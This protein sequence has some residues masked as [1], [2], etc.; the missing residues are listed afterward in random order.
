MLKLKR[1]LE[2]RGHVYFQTIRPEV[3]LNALNWLKVNDPSYNNISEDIGNI[4]RDLTTSQQNHNV[5]NED[6]SLL[7]GD[8]IN[9][10]SNEQSINDNNENLANGTMTDRVSPTTCTISETESS[11]D[12][13]TPDN[14]EQD[15][16]LNNFRSPPNETC[17]LQF[18]IPDN[19]SCNRSRE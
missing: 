7:D 8:M 18:I 19:L 4:G 2:F 10:S 15:D 17:C 5:S 3:V 9:T 16:P 14:E 11:N 13:S 1:K 12:G 6:N